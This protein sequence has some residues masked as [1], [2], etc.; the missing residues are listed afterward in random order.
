M[1]PVLPGLVALALTAGTAFADPEC[2]PIA[3]PR[4]EAYPGTVELHVNATDVAHRVVHVHEMVPVTGGKELVLLYPE[5]LPGT[6]M[7]QGRNRINKLAGLMIAANRSPVAW[8]RDTCNI[9]A[10]RVAVP[11]S[12]TVLDIDFDYLSPDA[13][14]SGPGARAE[15]SSEMVALEWPSVVLYPAGYYASRIAVE[16]SVTLPDAWQFATALDRAADGATPAQFKRA[17]LETLI[18]SPVFAGRYAAR[19]ELDA[20]STAPVRLN[21]FADRPE[22]LKAKDLDGYLGHHRA[23]VQQAYKLFGAKHYDHYD[24]LV[25]L[26]E[27]IAHGGL[28]HHRSSEDMTTADYFKDWDKA[29]VARDLLPHEYVHSWNGKFRRPKDLWTANYNHP[30]GDSLLWVYE[31]QTQYWGKMLAAR[32]GLWNKEQALDSLANTAAYFQAQAG[33]RWRS[34]QDTTYDELIAPRFLPQSWLSW[35]R[36]EDYYDEGVLLWLDVDTLIRELSQGQRSLD[37]FARAFFGMDDGGLGPKL[38]TFDDVTAALNAVQP[39][40]WAKFL[41][42]RLDALDRDPLDGITRGGYKLA[43]TDTPGKFFESI[44]KLAE[45]TSFVYSLGVSL[46][47][48]GKLRGVLWESPAFKAGLSPGMQI[49]AVNGMTYSAERIKDAVKE[50]KATA[51]PIE[52]IVKDEDHFRVLQIDY[53]GGARYPHLERA[54]GT[55]ARLDDILAAK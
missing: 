27:H 33:R 39:Y 38:Y 17:S 55:P 35:R 16:A 41:R 1:R 2:R 5:W 31:G 23:L 34:L 19:W 7:A 14:Q 52:L 32:A 47:K 48:G 30:M 26:S 36:G 10:F 11:S 9:F 51:A 8:T 49:Q 29:T 40:D 20:G 44:E 18:D 42:E 50:S 54:E 28:E 53:H 25:M 13:G 21:A 22:Q 4:D 43:F 12:A 6:H 15:I 3:A 24:F 46:D 37:D 45:I